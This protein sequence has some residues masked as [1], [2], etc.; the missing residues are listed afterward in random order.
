MRRNG[1]KL[2]C[3]L[4]TLCLMLTVFSPALAG[5]S[6]AEGPAVYL[7]GGA[8]VPGGEVELTVE[9]EA[10]R[11]L[12]L[13]LAVGYDESVLTLLEVTNLVSGPTFVGSPSLETQPYALTWTAMEPVSHEGAAAKL[14]FAVA[15]DA[16]P[17]RCAVTLECYRGRDGSA[18]D[19]VNVNYAEGRSPLG[20]RYEA[21]AVTVLTPPPAEETRITVSLGGREVTL[22]A[23]A[24][25]GGSVL[26]AGF[27]DGGRLLGVRIYPAAEQLEA[28]DME[29]AAWVRFMWL[30]DAF[31]PLCEAAE[32]RTAAN[33]D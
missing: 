23:H 6:G 33:T 31:I 26:A 25:M 32:L 4:L 20:L 13:S 19:G 3:A 16:E 12:N 14:R 24:A 21:E 9:T 17:G 15:A 28:E 7:R 2:L 5:E 8:A 1:K 29:G 11:F 10:L 18:V 30:D 27:T 22:T